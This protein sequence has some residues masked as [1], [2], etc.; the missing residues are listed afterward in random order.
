VDPNKIPLETQIHQFEETYA[1]LLMSDPNMPSSTLLYQVSI[2]CSN[3]IAKELVVLHEDR[4]IDKIGE[5]HRGRT[6]E[7]V[8]D[9][10][11]VE[12]IK[13]QMIQ[14][15]NKILRQL[16]AVTDESVRIIDVHYRK[17]FVSD[18]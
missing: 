3:L 4:F 10:M 16:Q 11:V 13:K 14:E 12:G 18:L 9:A 2:S 15:L 7:E 5:L 8:N 17:F 1:S 6:R